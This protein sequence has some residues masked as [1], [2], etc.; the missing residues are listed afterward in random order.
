MGIKGD[1]NYIIF[2]GGFLFYMTR[3]SD[4]TH[5]MDIQRGQMCW[6]DA[7]GCM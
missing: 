4:K 7:V 3:P 5:G 1:C 2:Y 6:V